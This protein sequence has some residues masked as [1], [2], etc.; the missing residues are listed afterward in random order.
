[1]R[2]SIEVAYGYIKNVFN[3]FCTCCGCKFRVEVKEQ[4]GY[5]DR[6]EFCCPECKKEYGCSAS[7]SPSISITLLE[8]RTDDRIGQH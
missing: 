5:K 1:M 6:E 3:M 7:D 2:N 8:R 4:K